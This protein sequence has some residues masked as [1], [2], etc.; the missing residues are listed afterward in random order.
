M[1]PLFNTG[2]G[3]LALD[4]GSD[5]GS[6][7]SATGAFTVGGLSFGSQDKNTGLY[8]AAAVVLAAL[9]LKK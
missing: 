3:S 9:I 8:I 7:D 6:G 4:S 1:N 2:G 5:A